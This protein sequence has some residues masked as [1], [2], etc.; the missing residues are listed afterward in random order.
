MAKPKQAVSNIFT[1]P[2]LRQM[3]EQHVE[4]WGQLAAL[5]PRGMAGPGMLESFILKNATVAGRGHYG[6][7]P[8]GVLR[9]KAKECFQNAA[10]QADEIGIY[11][12]CEGFAVSTASAPLPFLHAWLVDKQDSI[13]DPTLKDPSHYEYLGI[14]VPHELLWAELGRTGVYGL[15]DPGTG[16]NKEFMDLYE[17][18]CILRKSA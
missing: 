12:Y 10:T 2:C 5:A 7:L 13:I 1:Q 3:L 8:S 15:L 11:T 4:A 18:T 16:L 6:R 9:G 14:R 17:K